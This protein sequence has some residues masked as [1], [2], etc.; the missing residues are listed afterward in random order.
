MKSIKQFAANESG[1]STVEYGL[2]VIGVVGLVA[3]AFTG[4]GTAI[5]D[6]FTRVGTTISTATP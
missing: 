5:T 4:L 3:T 1:A 6:L 2:V